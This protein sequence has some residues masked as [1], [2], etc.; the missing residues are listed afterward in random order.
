MLEREAQAMI[1]ILSG[2]LRSRVLKTP[3]DNARTRPYTGRA[4][5]MVFNHLRG[6]LENAIVLDLFSGCGTIGIEALS[7]G[8]SSC[9]LVEQ[10]KGIYKLL[11]QNI[12]ELNLE[13]K[14]VP[15]LGDALSQ[16]PLLTCPTPINLAFLDPPYQMM[17]EEKSRNRI[18][19]QIESIKPLL[20]TDGYI[21]LRTP[22]LSQIKLSVDTLLGP[23]T[24]EVGNSMQIHFFAPMK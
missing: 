21:V 20:A 11:I 15:I 16:T 18:L 6:H 4:R 14:A 23:E 7:R 3:Q 5:E 24:H 10:H 22:K 12:Q 8:A 9:V 17:L 1:K 2:A 19:C 13:N